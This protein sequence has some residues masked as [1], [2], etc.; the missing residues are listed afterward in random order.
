MAALASVEDLAVRLGM[1]LE[2]DTADYD[3]ALANLEDISDRARAEAEHTD[4]ELPEDCPNIVRVIV[5]ATALRVFRN[6]LRYQVNQAGMFM[7][8]LPQADFAAGMFLPDELTKLHQLKPT[9]GVWAFRTTRGNPS[10]MFLARQFYADGN[11]GDDILF[12]DQDDLVSA[13]FE[14]DD[15]S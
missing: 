12:L 15:E 7:S 6:P 5:L 8:T 4:W 9:N 11:N 1:V 2:E 3:R 10:G 13:S 14:E